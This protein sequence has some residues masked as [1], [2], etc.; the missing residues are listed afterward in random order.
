MVLREATPTATGGSRP[1]SGRA[2]SSCPGR[3]G[4]RRGGSRARTPSTAGRTAVRTVAKPSAPLKAKQ[5][6]QFVFELSSPKIRQLSQVLVGRGT[7]RL[8]M[9]LPRPLHSRPIREEEV[10][11][12]QSRQYGE[13]LNRAP[14]EIDPVLQT[15]PISSTFRTLWTYL[16][17][18]VISKP[19]KL[20]RHGAS[21][22]AA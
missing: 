22:C 18:T 21:R 11:S 5:L 4:W 10:A 15:L 19:S 8:F 12:T 7:P 3:A 16:V 2:P 1:R 14:F 13:L 20:L 17:D 9:S 6:P